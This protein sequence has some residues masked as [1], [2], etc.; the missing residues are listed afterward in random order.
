MPDLSLDEFSRYVYP[1]AAIGGFI[2][3]KQGNDPVMPV[4]S[5]LLIGLFI[6]PI[7]RSTFF[8]LTRWIL[9]KTFRIPQYD[10]HISIANSLKMSDNV[11]TIS[12]A[13]ACAA[14]VLSTTDDR[15]FS[16]K[17]A[18]FNTY[19]HVLY[20]TA[21]LSIFA[22]IYCLFTVPKEAL[23]WLI[24]F[25]GT[26]LCGLLLDHFQ[27]DQRECIY[28]KQHKEEYEKAIETFKD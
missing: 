8:L 14:H 26:Y 24:I 7:Y 17:L 13:S 21:F 11:K 1:G 23:M 4:I 10:F 6:Y 25:I 12:K 27:A 5:A 2:L 9:S 15:E 20:M 3:W 18:I 22:I 16:R 19:V 28:L